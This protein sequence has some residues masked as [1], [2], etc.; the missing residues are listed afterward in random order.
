MGWRAMT[1]EVPFDWAGVDDRIDERCDA[2]EL[3][4]RSGQRPSIADFIGSEEAS[5]RKTLFCELLLVELECRQSLGE[6]PTEE[7]YLS[8]FPEFVAQIRATKFRNGGTAFSTPGANGENAI[9]V[10]PIQRGSHVAHFDFI[11]RLGVGAVGEAW[12]AWDSRLK[13]N[14]TIKLPHR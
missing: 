2:F 13:R 10:V 6:Q 7:Q 5:R 12:K 3:A 1:F 4:W 14:V 9:P 11:E 8:E